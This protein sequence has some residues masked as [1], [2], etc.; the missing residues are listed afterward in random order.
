M[1]TKG[2]A[3]RAAR[4]DSDGTGQEHRDLQGIPE[5][6]LRVAMSLQ[7]AHRS[8][9]LH[10][11][12]SPPFDDSDSL[13]NEMEERPPSRPRLPGQALTPEEEEYKVEIIRPSE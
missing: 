11:S 2:K 7:R 13:S 10:L 12:F 4:R 1:I 8:R 9:R 6:S 5:H 3:R